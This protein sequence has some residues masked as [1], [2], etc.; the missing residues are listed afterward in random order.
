[1][2]ALFD[3][4]DARS[5]EVALDTGW[6]PSGWN[7]ATI[8]ATRG[9]IARCHHLLLNE[10]EAVA[11]ARTSDPEEAARSLAAGMRRQNPMVVVKQG[12]HGA[13]ACSTGCE[14]L[15]VPAL[16]VAVIDTIGAGDAF[17]AGYL[18]S[19]AAGQA[20]EEALRRGVE[21]A[22]AAISAAHRWP[23]EASQRVRGKLR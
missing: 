15:R 7:K 10:V 18:A 13:L 3:W 11:L 5:I 12:P 17:N 19:V 6:P 8:V 23:E 14:I 2:T 4:A 20:T 16:D 22:S 1:M 9:W 21:T